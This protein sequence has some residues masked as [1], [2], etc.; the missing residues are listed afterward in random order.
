[1]TN[2]TLNVEVNISSALR[3]IIAGVHSTQMPNTKEAESFSISQETREEEVWKKIILRCDGFKPI[4]FP[5]LPLFS[6][7]AHYEKDEC[8]HFNLYLRDNGQIYA[9]CVIKVPSSLSARSFTFGQQIPNQTSMQEFLSVCLPKS[10]ISPDPSRDV[11]TVDMQRRIIEK[12]HGLYFDKIET[13]FC[14]STTELPRRKKC[15]H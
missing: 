11:L 5:G 6:H 7:P 2:A 4:C 14:T 15:L 13:L 9:H 12:L 3:D 10:C 1:M 8:V